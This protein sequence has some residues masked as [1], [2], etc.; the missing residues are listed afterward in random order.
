MLRE[1]AYK[2]VQSKAME[3]WDHD[4]DFRAAI[5]ADPEINQRLSKGQLNESFSVSRQLANIDRIFGRVF[6]RS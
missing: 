4:G 5:E 1:Q 3:A 6:N 2:T